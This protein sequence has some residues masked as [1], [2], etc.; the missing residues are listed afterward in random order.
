MP[1]SELILRN[2]RLPLP[3]W[4]AISN[5]RMVPDIPPE[6]LLR[7]LFHSRAAIVQW[8][9]KDLSEAE[10]R[11]YVRLGVELAAQTGKLFLVN[12]AVNLAAEEGAGG[13]HLTS[14]Q[15]V[16]EG[17]RARRRIKN[18]GW[19]VGRSVHSLQEAL[20]SEK[21]GA[22]YLLAGPVFRPISKK[23]YLPPLGLEKLADICRKLSVPVFALGGISRDNYPGVIA[24]GAAGIA[25]ISWTVNRIH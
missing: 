1:I 2:H 17:I 23:S 22:D 19:V 25:G 6:D 9:E 14:N 8:R 12:S 16:C 24:A 3:V 10:N 18:P 7:M 4:Y 15:D 5:R 21:A 13:V 20:E 11:R